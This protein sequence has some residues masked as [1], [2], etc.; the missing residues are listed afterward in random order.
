[1]SLTSWVT[2]SGELILLCKA[3]EE[4]PRRLRSSLAVLFVQLHQELVGAAQLAVMPLR[5]AAA[6]RAA[7][8]DP[9]QRPEKRCVRTVTVEHEVRKHKSS[10]RADVGVFSRG[11]A[12]TK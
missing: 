1:M 6:G 2:E 4:G 5:R 8:S 7:V 11:L 10:P 3:A 12:H 9:M